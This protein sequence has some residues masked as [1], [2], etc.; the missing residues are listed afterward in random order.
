[1]SIQGRLSAPV[2][3]N[4]AIGVGTTS[5]S[6][7]TTGTVG[8]GPGG[9]VSTSVCAA[10]VLFADVSSTPDDATDAVLLIVAPPVAVTVVTMR[11]VLD[12]PAASGPPP[13]HITV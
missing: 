7:S 1:M 9:G 11:I 6:G 2:V 12:W 3:G 13:V 10:E 4:A 8:A 5:G